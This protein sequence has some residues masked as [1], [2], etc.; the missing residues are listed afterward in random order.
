MC[1]DDHIIFAHSRWHAVRDD[2]QPFMRRLLAA[3]AWRLRTELEGRA[4]RYDRTVVH[5]V[6]FYL[7]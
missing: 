1:D 5:S 2:G 6:N 3:R 4:A 7:A